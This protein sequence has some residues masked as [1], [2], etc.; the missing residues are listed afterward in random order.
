M[1]FCKNCSE[2]VDDDFEVCWNCQFDKNGEMIT[3]QKIIKQNN[4]NNSTT[5]IKS[6]RFVNEINP[7]KILNAGKAINDIVLTA[8]FM[9]IISIIGYLFILQLKDFNSIK[10]W[11]YILAILQII[12]ILKII[13]SLHIAGNNFEEVTN[14]DL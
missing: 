5:A 7:Q 12:C 11:I 6:K 4:I 9:F 3:F 8:S 1:W 14:V 13:H 10:N 2:E